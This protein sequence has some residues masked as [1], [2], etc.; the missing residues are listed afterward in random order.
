MLERYR[1]RIFEHLVRVES[2]IDRS[3]QRPVPGLNDPAPERE[4]D[5][6][7]AQ[8]GEIGRLMGESRGHVERLVVHG[9]F[10]QTAV[11]LRF[12]RKPAVQES[13]GPDPPSRR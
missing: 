10:G 13:Q 1:T 2:E 7:V 11:I 3:I 8:A 12:E 9:A 6:P 4:L 5:T